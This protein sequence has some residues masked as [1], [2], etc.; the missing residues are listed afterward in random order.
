M[1]TPAL[2]DGASGELI[3]SLSRTPYATVDALSLSLYSI[4][5]AL[6]LRLS[7][8][9]STVIMLLSSL[10]QLYST[11]DVPTLPLI[12][13]LGNFSAG[14]VSCLK[15]EDSVQVRHGGETGVN[16]GGSH[17]DRSSV[18]VGDG[19]NVGMNGLKTGVGGSDDD[20]R[21]SGMTAVV[22][23]YRELFGMATVV[24]MEGSPHGS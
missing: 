10:E 9:Y 15:T 8:P 2:E 17:V 1:S 19:G 20:E 16:T 11:T 4:V 12:P 7:L 14:N 13:F 5:I 22:N 23:V 6:S 21:L 24:K 3:S 18:I